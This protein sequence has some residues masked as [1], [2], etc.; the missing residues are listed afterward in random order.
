MNLSQ[1][2]QSQVTGL[3]TDLQAEIL[4]FIKFVKYRRRTVKPL[5]PLFPPTRL[6]EVAGCLRYRGKAKTIE[7]MDAAV[8]AKF[9]REWRP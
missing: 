2:I 7:A 6:E 3:S 4:D 9:R 1:E 5:V 8:A